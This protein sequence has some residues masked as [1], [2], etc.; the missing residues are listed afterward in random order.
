M[1]P[2]LCQLPGTLEASMQ[3]RFWG[4]MDAACTP[5]VSSV[6]SAMTGPSAP[7]ARSWLPAARLFLAAM[8]SSLVAQ[9]PPTALQGLRAQP[10]SPLCLMPGKED[11]P[12]AG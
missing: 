1:T 3:G 8:L 12:C 4:Q 5:V 7:T 6:T 9:T 10:A 2:Y 11:S